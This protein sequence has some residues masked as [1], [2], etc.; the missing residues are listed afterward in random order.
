MLVW[1]ILTQAR[2]LVPT[3]EALRS[4]LYIYIYIYTH[5]HTHTSTLGLQR[6]SFEVCG[7]CISGSGVEL[8]RIRVL[9]FW[10]RVFPDLP[11]YLLIKEHTLN[12]LRDPTIS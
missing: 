11:I 9:R 1:R 10:V 5:T 12:H 3:M 8:L 7:F 6:H 4:I 2:I